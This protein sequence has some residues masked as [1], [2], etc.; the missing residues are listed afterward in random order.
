[1]S[2]PLFQQSL[3]LHVDYF[4][5]VDEPSPDVRYQ[6]ALILGGWN[7][8]TAGYLLGKLAMT[9]D[10]WIR[11][12]V[13]SSATNYPEEICKTL[14]TATN[15]PDAAFVGQ[16]CAT[17]VGIGNERAWQSILRL[18][19]PANGVPDHPWQ[20]GALASLLDA[21]ERKKI[22]PAALASSS[23]GETRDAAERLRQAVSGAWPL[24]NDPKADPVTRAAAVRLLG[25]GENAPADDL[26]LLA[27]FLQAGTEAPLQSAALES[28]RRQ[29]GPRLA[30][31]LL[32]NSGWNS[33]A[34]RANAA[35]LLLSR[36]EWAG[37]LLHALEQGTV[38]PGEISIPNRQRFLKHANASLRERA[39]KLFAPPSSSVGRAG[40]LAKY[41]TVAALAGQSKNGADVFEKNCSSCHAYHG[42]G[43][44]VGPNLA[45]FAGKSA[46]D[47]VLAILDPNAAINPNFL[48]WNIE[49]K[50]GRNLVGVVKGETTSSLTLIQ[51]GGVEENIL[52]SDIKEIRASSLSL[53]PEGLEQ[54]MNPQQVADLIAWIKEGDA[55]VAGATSK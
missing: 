27:T 10:P 36:D 19:T 46:P 18:I 23:D 2:E 20:W 47:F 22:T 28:L 55:I 44:A 9:N 31:L 11:A 39:E 15:A 49:T 35:N 24:V 33:P 54:N 32:K 41:Q 12:A 14:L 17:A 51:G 26:A 40:V 34:F 30:E 48:A 21:L 1:M 43:H 13:L 25:R 8:R 6:L 38:S 52:R 5:R 16:L 7:E 45:E 42:R 53:M 50:D 4:K 29:R 3:D 37:E